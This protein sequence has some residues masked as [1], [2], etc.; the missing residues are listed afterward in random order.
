MRRQVLAQVLSS[1]PDAEVVMLMGELSR[2]GRGT[3]AAEVA[4]LSLAAVLEHEDLGYDRHV[5]LYEE[6]LR[7]GDE[8]VARLLL[9][10][11]R[12]PGTGRSYEALIEPTMPLG[13]RKTWARRSR[14]DM[15]DRLLHDPDPS[16]L[17]ILLQN[18]RVTERDAVTLA[19]RRPTTGAAQ[20]VVFGSRYAARFEVR[21]A[22]AFNP[23]TPVE[24]SARLLPAL[25]HA[26]LVD[27]AASHDLAQALRDTAE[28]L[29]RQRD[30]T[31]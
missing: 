2:L 25:P 10:S 14:R 1:L 18:P 31:R 19:A 7:S 22:L 12:Q 13:W 20:R 8:V 3:A 29:L 30:L 26:D 23:Y 4:L 15:L 16:V 21:R 5:D 28:V 6:A 9:T 11:G 27:V 24:L 17:E